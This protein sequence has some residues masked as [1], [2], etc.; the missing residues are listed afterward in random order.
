MSSSPDDSAKPAGESL[1]GVEYISLV[2]EAAA[3]LAQRLADNIETI[4]AYDRA[5]SNRLAELASSAQGDAADARQAADAASG[6]P[7]TV[8]C[9]VPQENR[10]PSPANWTELRGVSA[11]F[12]PLSI[13]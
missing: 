12:K 3:A 11:R 6:A 1:A 10:G 5:S 7:E 4:A 9:V 8:V 2:A 13:L